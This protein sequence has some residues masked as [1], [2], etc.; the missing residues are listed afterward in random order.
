MKWFTADQHFGHEKI[1]Q[2]CER[3]FKNA[4]LMQKQLIK[5]HNEVVQD[6]DDVYMLGDFST[7][8]ASHIGTIQQILSKLKGRK[9]L[10]LGNHDIRNPITLQEAGFYSVHYPYLEVEE[11]ICVHDPALSQTDRKHRFLCGHIHNLFEQQ[12]NCFNVGVDVRNYRPISIEEIRQIF[13]GWV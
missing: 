3:P 4:T 10:I 8:T 13:K 2:M 9:H 11:F 6:G 5:R 1:I 7:L 12:L